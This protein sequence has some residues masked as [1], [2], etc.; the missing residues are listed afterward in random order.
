MTQLHWHGHG[1]QLLPERAVWDPQQRLLLLADLHLG[2][3]ESFQASG[4]PLPSD[5]DLANLNRLLALAHRLRPPL[6]VVLGD[7]IHGSTIEEVRH[8]VPEIVTIQTLFSRNFVPV[9]ANVCWP[10]VW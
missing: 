6:V 10:V 9:I 8:L 2:K 3:A 5:G 1:L 7:L 4:V